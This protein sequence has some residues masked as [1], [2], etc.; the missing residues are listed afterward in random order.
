MC[1]RGI[2]AV[3][4]C[5]LCILFLRADAERVY[6]AAERR[7]FSCEIEFL[8]QEDDRYVMQVTAANTGKDFTGS[9]RL[10]FA[11][12]EAEAC[13]Y[14]TEISLPEGGKKQFTLTIPERMAD[15][16]AGSCEVSF[17]DGKGRELQRITKR[18][19]FGSSAG[20]I[21]MGIL[22]D[23]YDALTYLDLGGQQIQVGN[24]GMP[25]RL[26]ELDADN[27]SSYLDGLYYLVIDH[28]HAESLGEAKIKAIMDWVS[29]GGWLMIGTGEYA[30]DTLSGFEND[31][32]IAAGTVTE[33]GEGNFLYMNSRQGYYYA[34]EEAGVD[35]R[36]MPVASFSYTGTGVFYE[37]SMDNPSVY[38][39]IGDGSVTVYACSLA[40]PEFKKGA[41]NGGVQLLSEAA[42]YSNSYGTKTYG[43]ID[44]RGQQVLSAI[45][46]SHTDL[47]F[48]AL[49]VL[50][51]AYVVLAG[52]L[53]YLLL[54]AWKKSEWYWGA[55]PVLGLLFIG[56]VYLFGRDIRVADTK[57]YS[58]SLQ[59]AGSGRVDTWYEAYRSGTKTWQLLMND[60]YEVAGAG[61]GRGSYGSTSGDYHYLVRQSGEGLFIG[62]KPR[63]N[64]ESGYLYASGHAEPA[65]ALAGSGLALD[66]A[67]WVPT[68]TVTNDTG[69][70]LAL[71]AVY[72]EE[73][74]AVFRDVKAGES[75]DLGEEVLTDR[76]VY[77]GESAYRDFYFD[78]LAFRTNSQVYSRDEMAALY[79]G[80][81]LAM[82]NRPDGANTAL[83]GLTED[84]PKTVA[85]AC[86]EYAYRCL[87]SYAKMEVNGNAAD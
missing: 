72:H 65:G 6:A 2:A 12:D 84:A 17:L 57:V 23:D 70:D 47:D 55:A 8:K 60:N 24:T 18:K 51:L 43:D 16:S 61:F 78:L 25:V 52:P 79:I 62:M 71:L 3:L 28:Y 37:E 82:Q 76:C 11:S 80:F 83:V 38:A 59:E 45:D 34:Y 36:N 58:V 20:G 32:S 69:H 1:K 44:Y 14:D 19:V 13:A 22:S 77:N 29:K 86:D 35:F 64:F 73:Y 27:L 56:G 41:A 30:A 49:I 66:V 40:D 46:R 31:L 67:S 74:L 5:F 26:I 10:V 54:R 15:L 21:T 33:P 87:S 75:I 53:L 63:E 4:A 9:V 81:E 50:I 48:T 42:Y 39:C 68:G 85:G 7:D